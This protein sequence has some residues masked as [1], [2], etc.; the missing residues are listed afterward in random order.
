MWS[1]WLPLRDAPDEAPLLTLAA[2][3]AIVDSI[4]VSVRLKWP[5]DVLAADGR[6][7]AGILAE[8]IFDGA[9]L[10]GAIL[11]VG[12][13]LAWGPNGPP[14]EL[15]G[16]AVSL[17]ELGVEVND[18]AND[19]IGPWLA[20]LKQ[21]LHDLQACRDQFVVDYNAHLL[22]RTRPVRLE[23]VDG[24]PVV[25]Y[26]EGIDASGGVWLC[27]SDGGGRLR[28]TIGELALIDR[29]LT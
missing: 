21:R 15:A 29:P 14:V 18:G 5:N 26:I 10:R 16:N 6:K 19:V 9:A 20:A 27:R 8:A 4:A 7:L 25:G 3:L 22:D 2:G 17:R 13:N 28:T 12:L 1:T 11:G 23:G 24:G